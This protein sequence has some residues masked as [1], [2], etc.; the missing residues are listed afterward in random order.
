MGGGVTEGCTL[1]R[2]GAEIDKW[3]RERVRR[4]LNGSASTN[5]RKKDARRRGFPCEWRGS[6]GV[7]RPTLDW[8]SSCSG[9]SDVGPPSP[10][11][12]EWL[13]IGVRS[14]VGVFAAKGSSVGLNE[15]EVR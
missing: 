10:S 7:P 1:C 8:S 12:R 3:A 13:R 11:L 14:A 15:T 9:S 6:L 2:K 5:D 4:G